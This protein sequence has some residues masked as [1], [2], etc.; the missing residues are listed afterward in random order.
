MEWFEKI[1][2]IVTKTAEVAYEKSSQAV[3]VTKINF[4]ISEVESDIKKKY[5][6]L[7][8]KI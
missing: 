8:R 2:G 1:K 7:G 4:K 3:E 5:I 6:E